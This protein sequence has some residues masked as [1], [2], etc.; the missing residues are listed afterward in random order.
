MTKRMK[1][2]LY[3]AKQETIYTQQNKE[4]HFK[5]VPNSISF[6]IHLINPFLCRFF[7]FD[8]ITKILFVSSKCNLF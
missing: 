6:I 4:N 8:Q 3:W 2:L 1:F 5:I 7:Q